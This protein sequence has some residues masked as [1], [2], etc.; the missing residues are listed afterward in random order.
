VRRRRLLWQLYPSYLLITALSLVAVGVYA[1]RSMHRSWLETTARDLRTRA[2]LIRDEVSEL[3]LSGSPD[4]VDRLC[5]RLGAESGT[6]ITV[7]LPS[8]KVIGDSEEDPARMENHAD[9]PEIIKALSGSNGVST[10]YSPTLGINMMYAAIPL[11]SEGETVAVLRTSLPLTSIDAAIRA[12]YA[13]IAVGVLV[14]AA[15]AA[16]VSLFVSRRISRPIEDIKHGA[17]RFASGELRSRLAVP[18]SE[19]IGALAEAMNE[20]AAQLDDRI[21]ATLRQR[22]ELEAV[23]AS[24]IEGVLAVDPEERLIGMNQAAAAM[25]G[26]DPERARGQSIQE[27][28]RN[29]RL[30]EFAAQALSASEPVEGEMIV[31]GDQELYLQAHGTSLRDAQGRKIGA[32]V[33]LND[34]TRLRG[35][36]R[37]RREFVANVSHEL[38]TPITSI[39]GFV[40]TLLDGALENQTDAKRFLSV[41]G[42]Q[43]DRL[44]AIIEDLLLLSSIEQSTERAEVELQEA[45]IADVLRSASELCEPKSKE[46]SIAVT[47]ACPADLTLRVNPALLEEALVN[48]I[49]NAVKHSDAGARV[50]VEAKREQGEVVISVADQGCGI[51]PEHLPRLFERFYRV[52]RGRSRKLGGTGLGLAIVKHIALAHGGRVS[53]DSTPG[54]G[55]I[56][57]IHLPLRRAKEKREET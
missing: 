20:M 34:V 26:V 42:R 25:L 16:G 30:Q 27:V 21:G 39:K 15:L 45:G 5:K 19:E 18:D 37:M 7:I 43:A 48:L 13:R 31:A 38:R 36:E 28:I 3:V 57:R 35:L 10:R 12:L 8:G 49:D 52:D 4:Q 44:N 6:R 11:E 1:S 2:L 40:E 54:R 53:V 56:F 24:M 46:K 29:T 50:A 32:V 22:N 55:S 17:L 47:V 14:V 9:R 23:L 41:L 51:E 33:V